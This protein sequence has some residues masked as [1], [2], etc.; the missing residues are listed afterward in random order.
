MNDLLCYLLL[1]CK[2]TL[3]GFYSALFKLRSVNKHKSIL[4][5]VIK[6]YVNSQYKSLILKDDYYI[7]TNF[8][9]FKSFNKDNE[10]YILHYMM[11]ILNTIHQ[12]VN[13]NDVTRK[14]YK[15]FMFNLDNH[16]NN[17]CSS[18]KNIK[19]DYKDIIDINKCDPNVKLF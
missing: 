5:N 7:I 6:A 12:K 9:I 15:T 4:P 14:D 1:H 11:F 17:I 19:F 2:S 18:L 3:L 16:L 13:T 8:A 10:M